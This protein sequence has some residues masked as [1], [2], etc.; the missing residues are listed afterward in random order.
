MDPNRLKNIPLYFIIVTENLLLF[1]KKKKTFPFITFGYKSCNNN[2][3]FFG[4]PIFL[5]SQ[6]PSWV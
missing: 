4:N 2:I 5:G 6:I 3:F 1:L